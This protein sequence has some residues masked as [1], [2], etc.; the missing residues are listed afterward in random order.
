MSFLTARL[1][2]QRATYVVR[3]KNEVH[4]CVSA[5][6]NGRVYVSTERLDGGVFVYST[7]SGVG[8]ASMAEAERYAEER[9]KM[10]ERGV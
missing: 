8:F 10:L 5:C 2:E 1:F 6:S 4:V 9:L 3:P 7:G